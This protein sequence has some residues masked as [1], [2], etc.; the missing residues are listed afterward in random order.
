MDWSA[1]FYQ[2]WE[3]IARTLLVGVLA[4]AALVLALR[5]SGNRTLSK[6]NAFDLVVTVAL[7]SV[8]ASILLSEGV[9]LAEGVTAFVL[10]IALQWT[11]ATLSVRSRGFAKLVRSEPRLL[12][13]DGDKLRRA[14]AEARV[15][16]DE[17]DTVMRTSGYT[18]HSDV[19]AVILES[20]GSFSVV[21]T[22]D[23][24]EGAVRADAGLGDAGLGDAGSD[25]GASTG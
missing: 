23:K 15:T 8:L 18:D 25:D 7:G 2:G 9:A 13:R 16:D 6:L 1:M 12:V 14:M 17:I 11:V 10:L 5:V 3:G 19:S 4:Y 20:D 21:G 22:G 24:A